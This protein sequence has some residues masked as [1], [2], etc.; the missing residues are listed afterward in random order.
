MRRIDL[1]EFSSHDTT[2]AEEVLF[3]SI[4]IPVEEWTEKTGMLNKRI[5]PMVMGTLR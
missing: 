4:L 3:G 2:N 1:Y 5:A